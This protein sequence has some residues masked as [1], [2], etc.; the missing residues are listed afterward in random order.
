MKLAA[1]VIAVAF[2]IVFFSC[3]T[4]EYA[5]ATKGES[6]KLKVEERSDA[7]NYLAI[8]QQ[9]IL[10]LQERSGR[11]AFTPLAGT[12]ISLATDMVKK[13]IANERKKYIADYSLSVSDLY[14]YDQLSTESCFDPVGMQFSG[15]TV[16]RTFMNKENKLDTAMVARFE[17]DT[18]K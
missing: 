14:F 18:S 13:M 5:Y 1:I 2:L 10:T 8:K 7:I 6:V 15:F 17:L 4:S 12:A 11:G 3:K 16:V 9:K